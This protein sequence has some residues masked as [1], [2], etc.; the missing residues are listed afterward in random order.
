VYV[1]HYNELNKGGKLKEL[2]NVTFEFLIWGK[3]WRSIHTK[4][5]IINH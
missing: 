2:L 4:K 1:K 5:F 3:L